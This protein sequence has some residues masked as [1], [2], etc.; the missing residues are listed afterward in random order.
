MNAI[1]PLTLT[2]GLILNSAQVE[3]QNYI[4]GIP[5]NLSSEMMG[6]L[7][8]VLSAS[9]AS[10]RDDDNHIIIEHNGSIR[11][12]FKVN[13]K[14]STKQRLRTF[15][16][17]CGISSLF[18]ADNTSKTALQDQI[19]LPKVIN[20]LRALD[21]QDSTVYL[22]GSLFY[23]NLHTSL[24]FDKGFPSDA[25][26]V[27]PSGYLISEFNTQQFNTD[28]A[29]LKLAWIYP[30]SDET[31][32]INRKH[33]VGLERFYAL[34][35]S[36]QNINWYAKTSDAKILLTGYSDQE[37]IPVSN[38]DYADTQVIRLHDLTTPPPPPPAK[39]KQVAAKKAQQ[40]T[41]AWL[42]I[43][44]PNE[45]T[46]YNQTEKQYNIL[47]NS[48]YT[49]SEIS[50]DE[51][52]GD[53]NQNLVLV[54]GIDASDKSHLLG[55]FTPSGNDTNKVSKIKLPKTIPINKLI[56]TP[57]KKQ[58]FLDQKQ[59]VFDKLGGVWKINKLKVKVQ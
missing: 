57:V 56:L 3:A 31:K 46:T 27:H 41:E 39:L 32:Y 49:T 47:L 12:N 40:K 1:K 53:N 4:Y 44:L 2:L 10:L 30:T 25:H 14:D 58:P 18:N 28:L 48:T 35:F 7:D 5:S 38:V 11:C 42:D 6:N 16:K 24:D 51:S 22:F 8:T 55:S 23:K 17:I 54:Y 43:P 29:H 37:A 34:Y 45:Y 20:S 50:I 26:V 52:D 15:V 13:A 19:N 59:V 9:I 21:K 33:E 36:D